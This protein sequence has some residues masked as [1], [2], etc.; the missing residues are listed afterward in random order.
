MGYEPFK[1]Y[2]VPVYFPTCKEKEPRSGAPEE[3]LTRPAAHINLSASELL[4]AATP[5]ESSQIR[6]RSLYLLDQKEKES[7]DQNYLF[8]LENDVDITSPTWLSEPSEWSQQE[9]EAFTPQPDLRVYSSQLRLRDTD[10]EWS[11]RPFAAENREK[12]KY[13]DDSSLR[14]K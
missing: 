1:P 9:L 5:E 13:I 12:L 3:S 14:T 4:L 11:F 8:S 6:D 2:T 7:T 10:D